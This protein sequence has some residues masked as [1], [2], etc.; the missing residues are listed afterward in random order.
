MHQSQRSTV[1]AVIVSQTLWGPQHLVVVERTT[2]F[3]A[4]LGPHLGPIWGP[5]LFGT[6]VGPIWGPIVFIWDPFGSHLGTHFYIGPYGV[7]GMGR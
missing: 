6:H 2:W 7:G 4:L 5:I 3:G 1:V